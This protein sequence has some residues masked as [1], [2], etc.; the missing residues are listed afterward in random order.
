MQ[1]GRRRLRGLHQPQDYSGLADGSHTFSVKAKDAAGNLDPAGV[2]TWTVDTTRLR[3]RRSRQ[4]S[5]PTNQ[6]T[7]SFSFSDTEAG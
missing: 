1:A 7:A 3:L 6:T 5:N 2:H 4:P